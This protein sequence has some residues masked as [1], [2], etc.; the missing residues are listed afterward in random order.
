LFNN[1]Q[2]YVRENRVTAEYNSRMNPSVYD[3]EAINKGFR[4]NGITQKKQFVITVY[5]ITP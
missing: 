5:N 3:G 1:R 2:A 4:G